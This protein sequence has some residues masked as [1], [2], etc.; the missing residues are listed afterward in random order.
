M[1]LFQI[2]TQIPTIKASRFTV[3]NLA[4]VFFH[5]QIPRDIPL[6]NPQT[7]TFYLTKRDNAANVTITTSHLPH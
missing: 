2:E 7:A 1:S 4:N 6:D 3:H 5:V